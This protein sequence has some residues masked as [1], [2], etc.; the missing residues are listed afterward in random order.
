M[1]G[2]L[3]AIGLLLLVVTPFAACS[4]S[5]DKYRVWYNVMEICVYEPNRSDYLEFKLA[6]GDVL[7]GK[8]VVEAGWPA[9][10]TFYVTDDYSRRIKDAGTVEEGE[11][12]SFS[13]RA[14]QSGVRYKAWFSYALLAHSHSAKLYLNRPATNASHLIA[15][16]TIHPPPPR[17]SRDNKDKPAWETY[18]SRNNEYSIG[19]PSDW[20]RE[21]KPSG[22][23]D[24]VIINDPLG[25]DWIE[26]DILY[27]QGRSPID[28][29]N[30]EAN[31][32]IE[33]LGAEIILNMPAKPNSWQLVYYMIPRNDEAFLVKQ[34]F[35]ST[36]APHLYL[37]SVASY[38]HLNPF[39][40]PY[41]S[42]NEEILDA[43]VDSFRIIE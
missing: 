11:D 43:I 24:V 27:L 40:G 31:W 33:H 4:Q 35:Y 14:K 26:V 15:A 12:Y 16:R 8:L 9:F 30:Q 20:S 28:Q 17:P 37:Y 19:H 25:I 3:F 34:H 36:K 13:I 6:K 5:L 10:V 2:L 41:L 39:G 18:I 7:N 21:I 23:H 22:I 38:E 29:V 1:R 42:Q 32:V